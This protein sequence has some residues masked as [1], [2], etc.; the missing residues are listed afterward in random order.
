MYEW[1]GKVGAADSGTNITR[2]WKRGCRFQELCISNVLKRYREDSWDRENNKAI[3]IRMDTHRWRWCLQLFHATMIP[4]PVSYSS[5]KRLDTR[6]CNF[7]QPFVAWGCYR[8]WLSF[9]MVSA[10]VKMLLY[11]MRTLLADWD[12][13]NVRF[14]LTREQVTFGTRSIFV[15]T[16]FGHWVSIPYLNRIGVVLLISGNISNYFGLCTDSVVSFDL[17][18]AIWITE[19]PAA[20]RPGHL[21]MIICCSAAVSTRLNLGPMTLTPDFWVRFFLARVQYYGCI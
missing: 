20:P 9:A 11:N 14:R 4:P 21:L 5:L 2:P 18:P 17:C 12:D 3:R 7:K 15:N 19:S 8:S 13:V 6:I 1:A 10:M 16:K